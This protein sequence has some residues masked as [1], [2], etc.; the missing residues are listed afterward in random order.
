MN[1]TLTHDEEF[2]KIIN[3]IKELSTNKIKSDDFLVRA[4]I[5]TKSGKLSQQYKILI[6]NTIYECEQK[7]R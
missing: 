6:R 1:N 5:H 4:G 3:Y 7:K 2:K